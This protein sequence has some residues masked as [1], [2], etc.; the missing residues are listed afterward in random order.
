MGLGS[1]G[2]YFWLW[3][4]LCWLVLSPD[5]ADDAQRP[6]ERQRLPRLCRTGVAPTLNPGDI[7][8]MDSLPAHKGAAVRN[9][10]EACG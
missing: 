2:L 6:N 10:I 4:T 5:C 1:S 9:A 7:V 8:V 3:R